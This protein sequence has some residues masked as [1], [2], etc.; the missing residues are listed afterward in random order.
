MDLVEFRANAS[1][2]GRW[3]R[4]WAR[5]YLEMGMGLFESAGARMMP[6][7]AFIPVW[8]W[9]A[10]ASLALIA[11]V[12]M[13]LESRGA[14]KAIAKVE[15][16]NDKAIDLAHRGAHGARGVRDPYASLD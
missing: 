9:K 12:V 7:L 16:S 15:R 4:D 3:S 5:R 6:W 1:H 8:L 11:G 14:E 2:V 13:Y 10:L